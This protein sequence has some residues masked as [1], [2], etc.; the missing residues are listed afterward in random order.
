MSLI[1]LEFL[2]FGDA[3][4][5]LFNIMCLGMPSKWITHLQ[6]QEMTWAA[7]HEPWSK[8]SAGYAL[9]IDN[10]EVNVRNK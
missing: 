3:K 2:N 8:A 7:S 4:I 6:L 9:Y 1:D 5:P 10:T